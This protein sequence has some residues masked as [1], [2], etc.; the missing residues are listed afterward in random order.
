MKNRL[1]VPV[2]LATVVAASAP[3]QTP[4][5]PPPSGRPAVAPVA[6]GPGAPDAGR[7]QQRSALPAMLQ[8]RVVISDQAGGGEPQK[9]QLDLRLAEEERFFLRT[10][11][12]NGP[13]SP[14][15]NADAR[16]VVVGDKAR[17]E[18][19]LEYGALGAPAPEGARQESNFKY[20][21]SAL[22]LEVGKPTIVLQTADPAA[23]R[24]ITIEVTL[25]PVKP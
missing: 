19:T 8:L 5:P 1:F 7:R 3:A 18:L 23:E 13:V 22:V 9:K 10:I 25:S 24:R 6:E 4:A 2:L 12:Q 17:L 11:A 15:L 14:R 20:Q 16:A 21:W